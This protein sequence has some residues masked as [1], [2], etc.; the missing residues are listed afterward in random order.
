MQRAQ[1]G[2]LRS[3][4]PGDVDKKK[5]KWGF[6]CGSAGKESVCKWGDLGLILGSG[7]YLGEGKGYPHQDS[8]VYLV[9]WLVKNPPAMRETWVQ[10]LGC[11]DPLEEG[12]STHFSILVWRICMD[13]GAWWAIVQGVTNGRT[14][15]SN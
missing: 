14:R 8:W 7:R 10:S 4:M 1:V 6:P 3:Y 2:E 5:K 11:E 15:L 12:M 9:A 13:R